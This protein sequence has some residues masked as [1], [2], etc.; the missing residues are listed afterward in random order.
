MIEVQPPV[1]QTIAYPQSTSATTVKKYASNLVSMFT[2]EF[3]M[4]KKVK[5]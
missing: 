2:S 5:F 4:E 3:S 1:D